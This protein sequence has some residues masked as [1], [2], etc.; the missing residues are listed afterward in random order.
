MKLFKVPAG[1]RIVASNDKRCPVVTVTKHENVFDLEDVLEDPVTAA[2]QE[3]R[4]IN[5]YTFQG[6]DGWTMKVL[7]KY[8]EIL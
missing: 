1:T 6:P 3:G 7:G 4:L 2:S 5:H 8:V